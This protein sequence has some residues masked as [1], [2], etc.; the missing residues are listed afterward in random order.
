[1]NHITVAGHLGS[2]PETRFTSSGTKVTSFRVATNQRRGGN[3]ETTWWRI[4]IWGEQ[5]DKMIPYLKKGSPIIVHGEL[6]KPEIYNG[7]DGNPQIS[8]NVTAQSLSFS[9]FGRG[10]RQN[11]QQQQQQPQQQYQ[12][13]SSGSGM[14]GNFG[15][16]MNQS[17]YE[18]NQ[19]GQGQEISSGISDE[20]IPF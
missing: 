1:M 2:E 3:D 7:K 16:D 15:N 10:D 14:G 4:T 6:Q 8:L 17:Y 19:Q 9:P 11:D 12:Q 5:F 13:Q 20:E 18:Q